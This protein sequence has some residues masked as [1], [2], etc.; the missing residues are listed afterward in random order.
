MVDKRPWLK[1]HYLYLFRFF[2][3]VSLIILMCCEG[4]A[5]NELDVIGKWMKYSDAKNSL[6]HDLANQAYKQ[7]AGRDSMISQIK[8]L[9]DW[10]QRQQ[11]VKN[12]LWNIVGPFPEKSPLNARVTKKIKKKDYRIENIIFESQPGYYV[13]ASL[14]IPS[15]LQGKAPAIMV[16]LGHTPKGHVYAHDQHQY[17]NLVKKGFI[18]F[19]FDPVGQGERVQYYDPQTGKS[20]VGG[21]THQHSYPGAQA[22]IVGTSQAKYEIWDGIRAVDYLLTREEVDP[23]RIGIT[24]ISGGGTQSAYIAAFDDRIYAAAPEN[25]VTNFTRLIQSIGPQDAEQNFY[26]EIASGIDHADLLEIRA[27]KPTLML[28]TTRDFFSIQGSIETAKEV[29]RI[30][31]AYGKERYFRMVMDDTTHAF[32]KKK[33]EAMYAFF[34]KYLKNP[35]DS[36][37]IDVRPLPEENLQVTKTGQVSTS[38]KG[39][40][41]IFDL[42]REAAVKCMDNLQSRRKNLAEYLPEVLKA[43][44]RLSGYQTPSVFHKPVFTGRYQKKGYVIEKHFMKGDGDYVIPYLL[45]IPD[46]ANGKAVICLNPNGKAEEINNGDMERFVKRGFMVLVP[47]LLDV[48]ELGTGDYKGDSYIDNTSYG[49][50]FL[51]IL[52]GRS[53]VGIAAGDVAR[54]VHLLKGNK[55]IKEIYGLARGSMCMPMLYAAAFDTA[56]TRIYFINPLSSYRSVVM[57]R[58]Y[59]PHFLYGAVAGALKAYDLPDLEA[60]LAPRK[61][62]MINIVNGQGQPVENNNEDITVVKEAYRT[63]GAGD[64]LNIIYDKNKNVNHSFFDW[65]ED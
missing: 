41:S 43:A 14:F 46:N 59:D 35:G 37:D 47:D 10:K 17:L 20:T 63:K 51:S 22:F 61:L 9:P 45:M 11:R 1:A 13:T 57:N 27:P 49:K 3:S 40:K 60:T 29:S 16:C 24:G 34:Q 65:I 44:K 18:V 32:S 39:A 19:A 64:Q 56:I 31:E 12:T 52:I 30:F 6:Y 53:I 58:F 54:L 23:S 33:R 50:W 26:H 15:G 42:N 38:I 21:P 2:F 62:T 28:T 4:N 5:Q 55:G 8:T 7:L 25:Y 36:G 48:G